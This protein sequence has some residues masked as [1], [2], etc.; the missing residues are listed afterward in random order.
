[1]RTLV[2]QAIEEGAVYSVRMRS[3][4]DRLP[5]ALQETVDIAH[6]SGGPAEI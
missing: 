1:M 2:R 4:G 6:A 5:E 3:E